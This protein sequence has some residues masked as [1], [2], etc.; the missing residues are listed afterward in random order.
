MPPQDRSVPI[1]TIRLS[2]RDRERVIESI[3]RRAAPVPAGSNRR[4]VRAPV[5][6]EPVI[7]RVTHPT[8]ST[9]DYAVLP[10]DISTRGVAFLHGQFLY[11][12]SRLA[13]MLRNITGQWITI[14]GQVR[15][16]QLLAGKL[17]HIRV[18]FDEPIDLTQ[19]AV[20][21]EAQ[22][23]AVRM[24][25]ATHRVGSTGS[26]GKKRDPVLLVDD[27]ELQRRLTALWLGRLGLESQGLSDQEAAKLSQAGGWS[28]VMLDLG[29]ETCPG[30]VLVGKLRAMGYAG[31]ILAMSLCNLESTQQRAIDAGCN[32]LLVKPFDQAQLAECVDSLLAAELV[33]L[34][35]AV[36]SES[37]PV[38]VS[39]LSG[40]AELHPLVEAFI[41]S[42]AEQVQT[43]TAAC[44]AK[45]FAG[46]RLICRALRGAGGSYGFE[47]IS[48]QAGDLERLVL[49]ADDAAGDSA[50]RS[51]TP[52]PADQ[53]E[54]A[55]AEASPSP[56][57]DLDAI[58]RGVESLVHLLSRASAE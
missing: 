46:L 30:T 3:N 12:Q 10:R 27:H 48:R 39:T 47:P 44:E 37:D 32:R 6:T 41:A 34:Q 38:L 35:N 42:L 26:K 55:S 52:T 51:P 54:A 11:P 45:D 56:A 57:H 24:E 18:V 2:A 43:L 5:S 16:C 7:V 1:D 36:G 4:G 33:R 9:V 28:L 53:P 19:F 22:A 25:A 58:Q 23:R 21:D 14:D 49:P 13:V 40:D 20:L 8:G 15:H 50:G 29:D 31:P 17:H